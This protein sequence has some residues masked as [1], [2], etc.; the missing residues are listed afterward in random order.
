MKKIIAKINHPNPTGKRIYILKI[1]LSNQSV[2]K[3]INI[4]IYQK[5]MVKLR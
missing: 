4:N 5:I 3:H 1:K 2:K